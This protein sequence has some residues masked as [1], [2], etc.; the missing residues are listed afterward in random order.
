MKKDRPETIVV[1]GGPHPSVADEDVLKDEN[2]E[3]VVR[4]E[5]EWTFAE[6][7]ERHEITLIYHLAAVLSARGESD[8]SA[9]WRVN[10][11]GL[12]NVLEAAR[13]VV[14]AEGDVRKM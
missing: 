2:V 1:A 12:R 13:E 9:T 11:D 4:G 14:A 8:P 10:M 6:V 3:F 7:L 5:G